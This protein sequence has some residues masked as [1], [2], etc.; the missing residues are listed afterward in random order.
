MGQEALRKEGREVP[1]AGGSRATQGQCRLSSWLSA[2]VRGFQ[3][4]G[5]YPAGL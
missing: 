3:K 5:D 4:W 1:L 2:F